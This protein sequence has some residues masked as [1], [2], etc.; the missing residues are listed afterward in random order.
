MYY[1]L[2]CHLIN[3]YFTICYLPTATYLLSVQTQARYMSC[4]RV[5]RTT[6]NVMHITLTLLHTSHKLP[7]CIWAA[8]R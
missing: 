8:E 4:P 2:L 5:Q 7:R 3:Y 1:L 6:Y